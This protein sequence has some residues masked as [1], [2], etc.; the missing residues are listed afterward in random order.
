MRFR[1]TSSFHS[2]AMRSQRRRS[3]T[4][5]KNR[6]SWTAR[7]LAAYRAQAVWLRLLSEGSVVFLPSIIHPGPI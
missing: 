5:A 2:R 7:R 3:P 4:D 6:S 1:H